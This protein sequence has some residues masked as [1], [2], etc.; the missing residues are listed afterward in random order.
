[1]ERQSVNLKSAPT[2]SMSYRRKLNL[3]LTTQSFP[4]LL[5]TPSLPPP[6]WLNINS[7]W[8]GQLYICVDDQTHFWTS[9]LMTNLYLGSPPQMR[10]WVWG[11]QQ[12]LSLCTHWETTI[13]K[14]FLLLKV[15]NCVARPNFKCLEDE[16]TWVSNWLW[17]IGKGKLN[18]AFVLFF[19]TFTAYT[20][21]T[22]TGGLGGN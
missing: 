17:R 1:M 19:A 16:S 8:L 18:R 5:F 21:T 22:P 15:S 3:G 12:L 11:G 2:A 10:L 9:S 13:S 7:G 14:P 4:L 20:P 6:L